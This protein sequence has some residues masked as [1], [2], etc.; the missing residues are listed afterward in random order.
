[1]VA[2]KSVAAVS[3]RVRGCT[4]MSARYVVNILGSTFN[5]YDTAG[6]DDRDVETVLKSEA[7]LQL[8]RLLTSLETGVNLRRLLH[9]RPSNQGLRVQ[10]L[11]SLPRDH[12]R[13]EV[14]IIIAITGLE[15]EEVMDEWRMQNSGTFQQYGMYPQGVGCI[16][17]IRGKHSR[18]GGYMFDEHGKSKIWHLLRAHCLE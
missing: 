13:N 3:G 6:L 7:I 12:L 2:E 4:F 16:T 1:M 18:S 15:Q 9:A 8:F 10:V 5:L 11:A 14:P 17:A